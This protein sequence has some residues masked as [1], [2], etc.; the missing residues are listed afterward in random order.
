MEDQYPTIWIL[1]GV[2]MNLDMYHAGDYA[3]L[4]AIWHKKIYEIN[5]ENAMN[6][7]PKT[8][9]VLE[10]V[11]LPFQ[12]ALF[13]NTPYDF[14]PFKE[15]Y[16]V[17]EVQG[18]EYFILGKFYYEL[19]RKLYHF[20][21]IQNS[22]E[23]I[24]II[25]DKNPGKLYSH[26]PLFVNNNIL[27]FLSFLELHKRYGDSLRNL[28]RIY[29]GRNDFIPQTNVERDAVF[30]FINS[31]FK[32]IY[33]ILEQHFEALDPQALG[34]ENAYWYEVMLGWSIS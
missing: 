9:R 2:I 7:S 31:E 34:Q 23:K 25:S 24:Y 26:L 28:R 14:S 6:L 11:G 18:V 32:I 33:K 21:G 30:T 12:E 13:F 17:Q 1:T 4:R 27:S 22:S 8:T 5:F 16:M 10:T 3:Y 29:Y 20:V 19:V 15:Q